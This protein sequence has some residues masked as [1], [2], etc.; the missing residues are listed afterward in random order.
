MPNRNGTPPNPDV[1]YYIPTNGVGMKLNEL[2][3]STGVTRVVGD[4]GARLKANWPTAMPRG[5]SP[6]VRRRKDG[7]YWCFMVDDAE[8]EQRGRVHLGPRHRHDPRHD[9]HQ[10]RAP[11]PRE[12][13][14][15]RQLLRGLRRRPPGHGGLRA[16]LHSQTASCCRSRSTPT[17]RIDANGDD[18]Y[19]SVDYQSDEGDVFMVNLRTG[20]RTAL[21]PTY[22]AGTA[23]ALHVSGKAF[24][25][26][27]WVLVCTY[28]DYGGS[29]SGCTRRSSRC[30]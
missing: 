30:S 15:Q 26:P 16:R 19:V 7:R 25:K 2:N 27:G 9:Q 1:L 24:N 17:S 10:R 28:G 29:S 8:L 23:T 5:P 11:R 6:K 14:P 3:V 13:E 22:V 21:F 20:V 4:F 12:H 18:A